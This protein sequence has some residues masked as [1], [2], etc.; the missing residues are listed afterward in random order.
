[1]ENEEK[2]GGRRA[3]LVVGDILLVG[4]QQ[5]QEFELAAVVRRWDI[6]TVGRQ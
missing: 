2:G 4:V 5:Q 6:A 1:M 3:G